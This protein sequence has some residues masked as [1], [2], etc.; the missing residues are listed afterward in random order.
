MSLTS[1]DMPT[2]NH[3][4]IFSMSDQDQLDQF[5]LR[6]AG[7]PAQDRTERGA[8]AIPVSI[9]LTVPA[10]RPAIRA[11]R[12]QVVD[13]VRSLRRSLADAGVRNSDAEILVIDGGALGMSDIAPLQA[14]SARAVPMPRLVSGR[15]A[16]RNCG[17]ARAAH[18]LVLFID[19]DVEVGPSLLPAL[20]DIVHNPE[21]GAVGPWLVPSAGR[22]ERPVREQAVSA[23]FGGC[24]LVRRDRA[25]GVQGFNESLK[26][27]L[28]CDVDFGLRL[29][30][31]GHGIICTPLGLATRP[32]AAMVVEDAQV[33]ETLSGM[34]NG[35][36]RQAIDENQVLA[37]IA[38]KLPEMPLSMLLHPTPTAAY[39]PGPPAIAPRE[40]PVLLTSRLKTALPDDELDLRDILVGLMQQPMSLRAAAPEQAPD[41]AIEAAPADQQMPPPDATTRPPASAAPVTGWSRSQSAAPVPRSPVQPVPGRRSSWKRSV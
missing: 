17:L 11:S 7:W 39:R 13:Q 14:Q 23:I 20:L 41:V 30:A 21:V 27:D 24:L 18:P 40:A 36:T 3:G 4:D 26:P 16:M 34:W 2:G 15:A 5:H 28:A 25:R 19:A 22:A 9:V 38:P 6:E 31:A 35:V 37:P 33:M 32:P 12:H 1:G 8:G 10:A 29:R